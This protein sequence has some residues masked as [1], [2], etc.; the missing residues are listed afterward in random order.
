M[1]DSHNI[2]TPEGGEGVLA[3]AMEAF[4]RVDLVVN[5]AGI[6]RDRTFA[7]M[8]LDLWNAVIAVHL[9]GAVHVALPAWRQM[10]DQGT[11][12]S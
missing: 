2:A 6:L 12:A 11:G 1:A 3:T 9:S 5:N 7:K 8:D 4:G 10:R